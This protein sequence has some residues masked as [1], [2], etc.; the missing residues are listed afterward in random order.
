[1]IDFII[2]V[3]YEVFRIRFLFKVYN[4]DVNN[5]NNENNADY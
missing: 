3:I 2:N 1:M 4:R 5:F